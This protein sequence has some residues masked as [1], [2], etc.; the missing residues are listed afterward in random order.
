MADDDAPDLANVSVAR[1]GEMVVFRTPELAKTLLRPV[2]PNFVDEPMGDCDACQKPFEEVFLTTGGLLG[3]PDLF[4]D[5]PVAVDGW[6]CLGCGTL[7]YPRR[8]EATQ[9]NAWIMEGAEH[10]RAGRFAEA[11]LC[12]LRVTWDWPGYPVAH[13][14]L[15]EATRDRIKRT[16]GAIDA[17]TRKRLVQRM[18]DND[19]DAIE[20]H[21]K[22]PAKGS[23]PVVAHACKA[24]AE[25]AMQEQS[26][27]RARRFLTRL[28]MT[29]GISQADVE[30][31]REMLEHVRASSSNASS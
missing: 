16:G 10:G 17:A 31:G 13:V 30:R 1:D 8:V 15:A 11:E 9:V 28:M 5:M 4:R 3:D 18:L 21:S 25:L 22:R 19:E 26:F 24:G 20:G 2:E 12:F 23:I 6:M 14:N 27:D 7:R 29:D